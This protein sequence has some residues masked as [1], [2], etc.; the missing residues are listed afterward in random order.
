MID[1]V[2]DNESCLTR[3]LFRNGARDEKC[4]NGVKMMKFLFGMTILLRGILA[5]SMGKN[6]HFCLK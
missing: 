5:R 6:A 4:T 3:K 1:G 2:N